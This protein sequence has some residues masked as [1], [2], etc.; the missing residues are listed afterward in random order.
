MHGV[1]S[2]AEVIHRT[3]KPAKNIFGIR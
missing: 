1:P 3:A 2:E